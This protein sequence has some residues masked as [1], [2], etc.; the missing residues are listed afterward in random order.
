MGADLEGMQ[1]RIGEVW[2]GGFNDMKVSGRIRVVIP[3]DQEPG[4]W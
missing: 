3:K 4:R 1:I 2:S